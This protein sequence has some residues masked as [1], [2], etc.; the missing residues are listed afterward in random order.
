MVSSLG[1]LFVW[2]IG[3]KTSPQNS[4][5]GSSLFTWIYVL[6]NPVVGIVECPL[7]DYLV[8]NHWHRVEKRDRLGGTSGHLRFSGRCLL[9]I[10]S[11]CWSK[12]LLV[13]LNPKKNWKEGRVSGWNSV[14]TS[15]PQIFQWDENSRPPKFTIRAIESSSQRSIFF[16]IPHLMLGGIWGHHVNQWVKTSLTTPLPGLCTSGEI[17]PYMTSLSVGKISPDVQRPGSG[18]VRLVLTHWLT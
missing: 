3:R 9:I 4:S 6:A 7:F 16:S 11:G 10:A 12:A 18:V 5:T 14:K 17:L 2:F 13:P 1:L 8:P 15:S